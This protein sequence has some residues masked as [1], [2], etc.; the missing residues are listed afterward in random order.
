MSGHH[1][2]GCGAE[3]RLLHRRRNRVNDGN[4]GLR[5]EVDDWLG[6]S[7]QKDVDNSLFEGDEVMDVDD[8][9]NDNGQ[10]G[11]GESSENREKIDPK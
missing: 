3:E 10:D 5:N 9:G 7:T 1:T 6:E 11:S 4:L 2:L 8:V